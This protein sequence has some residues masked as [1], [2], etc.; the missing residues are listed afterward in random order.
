MK[1]RFSWT[2]VVLALALV[3]GQFQAIPVVQAADPNLLT[4]PGFETG[5]SGFFAQNSTD[6]AVRSTTSPIA[7]TGSLKVT[8]NGYGNNAWWTYNTSVKAS[9]FEVSGKVRG[10]TLRSGST[11]QLCAAAYYAG[12]GSIIQNCANLSQVAGQ[13]NTVT[14]TLPLDSTRSLSQVA[15]R[16]TLNGSGPVS[17]SFDDVSAV[18]TTGA[19]PP[20]LTPPNVAVTAPANGATLSPG[21]VNVAA[22]AS[23]APLTARTKAVARRTIFMKVSFG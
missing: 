16:I 20:D 15:V 10:D 22:W 12:S 23:A 21:T 8:I 18:L 1:N 9:Q 13:V 14:A 11:M 19:P 4:D 17:Y 3:S 5:V 7:G 2:S 6:S